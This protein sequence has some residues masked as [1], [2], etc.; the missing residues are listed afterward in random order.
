MLKVSLFSKLQDGDYVAASQKS[1]VDDSIYNQKT[2]DMT[3]WTK[4]GLTV[5]KETLR[6]RNWKSWLQTR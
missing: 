6:F 2:V 5:Y 3:F 4:D 1:I